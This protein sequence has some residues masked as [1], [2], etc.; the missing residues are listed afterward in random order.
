MAKVVTYTRVSSDEQAEK[1]ISI[2]AQRKALHRYIEQMGHSLLQD[3]VDEGESAYAPADKRPGFCQMISYCRHH[4]VDWILVH[5]LDRFSRNREESIL[6]KSLLRKHD[7]MV[8]SIT[9]NYDPETPQGF[10]YEGMI[11]VINQFYSMNLATETLKGMKENA[12]R[13]YHNG[14]RTP[15]G[16]RLERIEER[17]HEHVRLVPGPDEEVETVRE[18]FRM[19]TEHGLG[20]RVIANEL[21]RRGV[22][23]PLSKW[24][25]VGT[26]SWMLEN[27]VY[28]GDL[29]WRQ[30]KKVGRDK[31]KQTDI[32]D[33]IIK[34]EAH[35]ALISRETFE[36]RQR[37]AAARRFQAPKSTTG[38]T[39]HLLGRLI[40]CG[41]CGGNFVSRTQKYI[42]AM[43]DD[44]AYH[45]YYCHNYLTKG[46]SVCTSFPLRREY[47]EGM[48]FK[49]LRRTITS[50]EALTDLERRVREKL[51]ARR[52]DLGQDPKAAQR[53]LAEVERRIQH[54]YRAIGDGLD[55][56]ICKQHIRRLGEQKTQLALE[57]ESLQ[58]ED[59]IGAAMQ[60]TLSEVNTF[61]TM[62][63]KSFRDL[64]F[65]VQRKI[66]THFVERVEIIDRKIFRVIVRVPI[67][68]RGSWI[69]DEEN[70]DPPCDDEPGEVEGR[71]DSEGAVKANL[72]S[73]E[74]ARGAISHRPRNHP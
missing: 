41:S 1:D 43:G 68:E 51:E 2:P 21:N 69:F 44:Q 53:K 39:K 24:W 27:R 48:V 23:G 42:T 70:G 59:Y 25:S 17:G 31:R 14:G 19:A 4:K 34:E 67:D 50:P 55:P 12:E 11:E 26:I 57:A 6:F 66:V 46:R 9:E 16:Y 45:R 62:F 52:K 65:P 8:K 33:W 28:V 72:L 56:D 18:I 38:P 61:A 5:K 22:P 60:H 20:C 37:Y 15:Y 74:E 64:P 32:S 13:G 3:F 29:V 40:R 30:S 47:S 63:E 58:R 10:L 54:Y 35:V 73:H 49:A 7:V 71:A 36:K